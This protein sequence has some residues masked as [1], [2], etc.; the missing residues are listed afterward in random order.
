MPILVE[1]TLE[2]IVHANGV[3]EAGSYDFEIRGRLGVCV[4]P[5]GGA[6]RECHTL[7][8]KPDDEYVVIEPTEPYPIQLTRSLIVHPHESLR[9]GG[10][11]MEEDDWSGDDGFGM[12]TESFSFNEINTMPREGIQVINQ[13][14]SEDQYVDVHWHIRKDSDLI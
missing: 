4:G 11:L 2:E 9:I 5:P 13:Y 10:Q 14:S 8:S 3:D 12:V 7:F 1:V 6:D